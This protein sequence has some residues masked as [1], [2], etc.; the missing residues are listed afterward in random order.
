MKR[1]SLTRPPRRPPSPPQ[2]PSS[3]ARPRGAAVI[4][5]GRSKKAKEAAKA[6]KKAGKKASPAVSKQA[7]DKARKA[8][9]AAMREVVSKQG[10]AYDRIVKEMD[11]DQYREYVLSVRHAPPEDSTSAPIA[12]LGD[13][14]P[15]CEVVVADKR[16]YEAQKFFKENNM[17]IP[18]TE[19]QSVTA[20]QIEGVPA[21]KA[22]IPCL[23]PDIIGMTHAMAGAA[24]KDVDVSELEFGIEQWGSFEN[25]VDGLEAQA[26]S[27]ARFAAAAKVLSVSVDD[28]AKDVKARYRKLIATEHPDRNPDASL[29]KFNAIKEAYELM[30]DRG[31][32]SG[33]TFEGLGD[34]A[35][36]DFVTLEGVHAGG[37]VRRGRGLVRRGHERDRSRVAQF[38]DLRP[39]QDVLFGAQRELAG[40]FYTLVPIRPRRRGGRRSLRTLPGVSL[41]PPLGFNPRPRRL[42]TPLTPLNSTPTFARRRGARRRPSRRK[43]PPRSRRRRRRRKRRRGRG[44]KR[45]S[46]SRRELNDVDDVVLTRSLYHTTNCY[47]I[48]PHANKTNKARNNRSERETERGK[49]QTRTKRCSLAATRV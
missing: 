42:S 14:L 45:A 11:R 26:S 39:H 20:E 40:A 29:E 22:M 23:G 48:A 1:G 36:R 6:D 18:E 15:I 5:C 16:A 35:K 38:D 37:D 8:A 49:R 34:K 17:T 4:R 7:K 3:T 13:W 12:V 46:R 44:R 30:S 47:L 9:A 41:R 32:Q 10:R 25:A 43:L 24:V 28:D 21:I 2:Q 33:A 27:K 19:Q 31:G